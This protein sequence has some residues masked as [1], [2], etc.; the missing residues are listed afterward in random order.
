MRTFT[1]AE[2]IL[3]LTE[4]ILNQRRAYEELNTGHKVALGAAG[5]VGIAALAHQHGYNAGSQGNGIMAGVNAL[6]HHAKNNPEGVS[7]TIKAV[8]RN[9]TN[10]IETVRNIFHK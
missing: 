9:A 5:A 8:Q 2:Y 10:A 1:K 7:G 4:D 3:Q 6:V